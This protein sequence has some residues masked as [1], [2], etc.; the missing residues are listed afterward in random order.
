MTVGQLAKRWGV[1][2]DRIMALLV[3]SELP[4][5][6]V[7]PSAGRRAETLKIPFA[8]VL[9]AETRWAFN[10]NGKTKKHKRPLRKNN[11]SRPK[12]RHFPEFNGLP[13]PH[14]DTDEAEPC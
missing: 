6:F 8:T 14:A 4:G 7:I 1:G 5:A 11:G 9:D 2:R 13:E 3:D 12:L 10:G